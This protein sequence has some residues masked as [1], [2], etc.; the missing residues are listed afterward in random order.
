MAQ[1][2]PAPR[3]IWFKEVKL[4]LRPFFEIEWVC[5]WI[6][7]A[8]RRWAWIEVL[9]ATVL[10]VGIGN[11]LWE[12]PKRRD[13]EI[14]SAFQTISIPGGSFAEGSLR[15]KALERLAELGVSLQGVEIGRNKANLNGANLR[16]AN[17]SEAD[18][19]GAFLIGA[20]LVGADLSGTKLL[21]KQQIDVA[22][23]NPAHPPKL[24][25]SFKPP[26]PC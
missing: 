26:P 14:Q 15:R 4:V 11:Y 25:E 19:S 20:I 24:P 16:K 9:S 18:L 3:K 7:Y 2:R 6:L 1:E 17:L 13:Q 22:C 8:I 21:T 12:I 10:L 23:A 5:E